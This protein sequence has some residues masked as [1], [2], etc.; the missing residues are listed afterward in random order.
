MGKA[1][2]KAPTA[3]AVNQVSTDTPSTAPPAAPTPP[4]TSANGYTSTVSMTFV[5]VSVEDARTDEFQDSLKQTISEETGVSVGNIT[6]TVT[7]RRDASIDVTMHHDNEE[8]ATSAS[9]AV[10]AADASGDIVSRI[11]TKL[12][13]K[14]SSVSVSG[15]RITGITRTSNRSSSNDDDDNTVVIA[16]CVFIGVLLI[17]YCQ[18]GRS[19]SPSADELHTVNREASPSAPPPSYIDQVQPA[20]G[21]EVAVDIGVSKK[22]GTHTVGTP[23]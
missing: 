14:G 4:P 19:K 3:P 23:I 16:V 2:T 11:N 22:E 21:T 13:A 12:T 9:D 5:N 10:S 15:T 7:E 6:V 20:A 18:F 8:A 17:L 1:P